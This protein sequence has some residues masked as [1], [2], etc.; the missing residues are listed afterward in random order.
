MPL[1]L[2]K[3]KTCNKKCQPIRDPNLSSVG[4]LQPK[5]HK[6]EQII[7]C[8]FILAFSQMAVSNS[9]FLSYGD[10]DIWLFNNLAFCHIAILDSGF[11]SYGYF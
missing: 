6:S 5:L 9:G 1:T 4:P 2:L 7:G 10:I 3:A 8:F 11:L